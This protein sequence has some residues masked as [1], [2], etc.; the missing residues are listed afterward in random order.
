M[1]RRGSFTFGILL[2]LLGAWFLAVRFVP[3]LNAWVEQFAGWPIWVLAPG[4][5]F[6]AAGL[7]SG[8][9][10]LMVPGSIISGVGLILY[11]QNETG[12]WQSW[13]YIWALIIV[14]VGVGVFLSNV[15]RGQFRRAFEEGG[16]PIMTGLV[17]FLI[18][19]SI[20]RAVFGQS[21]F[22]GEYWP[23]LL[24]AVGL[25]MLIK[26][27]FRKKTKEHRKNITIEFGDDGKVVDVEPQEDWEAELDAAFDQDEPEDDELDDSAE[28]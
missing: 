18:F 12:D 19:G 9:T 22:L 8:V 17:M 16:P 15:F 3:G 25:W 20:F 4:L 28:L 26:P 13:S 1:K 24:V 21:P 5:I 10:D 11:Y 23:L 2:I 7:I 6:I 27:L 14:A